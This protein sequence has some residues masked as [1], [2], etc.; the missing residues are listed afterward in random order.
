MFLQ[1]FFLSGKFD[2]L[3]DMFHIHL[4]FSHGQLKKIKTLCF[5]T[6]EPYLVFLLAAQNL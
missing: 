3:P 5:T 2:A 4:V 6:E 1:V